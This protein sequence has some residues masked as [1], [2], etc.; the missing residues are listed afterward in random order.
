[1]GSILDAV[2]EMEREEHTARVRIGE[3]APRHICPFCGDIHRILDKKKGGSCAK[4]G[5][6]LDG[7]EDAA[8][9]YPSAAEEPG[10]GICKSRV[11]DGERLDEYLDRVRPR[12]GEHNE[13]KVS[14][15]SPAAEDPEDEAPGMAAHARFGAAVRDG[16][17]VLEVGVVGDIP[18]VDF[19]KHPDDGYDRLRAIYAMA[20]EQAQGG[21]GKERHANGMPFDQQP[22]CQ[23]GRR[24]GAG[25]LIYQAWKK[26]HETP[27]L[28]TM[29]NGTERA[30]RELLGVIN[31]AAAA[32]IVLQEGK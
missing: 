30:I 5:R 29:D 14:Q 22:I 19:Y 31:Y 32:I 12:V 9:Q 23:G 21:K 4:C 6:W 16:I 3:N 11:R 15:Y 7:E 28:M 18:I 26:A 24:F 17:S 10:D 2:D 13:K 25:C 1:M 8:S 27:V 20:L